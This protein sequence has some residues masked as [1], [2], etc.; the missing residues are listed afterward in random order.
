MRF[1]FF[2]TLFLSTYLAGIQPAKATNVDTRSWLIAQNNTQEKSDELN[3]YDPFADYSEFEN[4]A[5]E[6]ENIN[7]FQTG[8]FSHLRSYGRYPVIY[9]KHECPI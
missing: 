6:Q 7:F 5:E 9:T 1:I 4:T 8:R 2:I 3:A